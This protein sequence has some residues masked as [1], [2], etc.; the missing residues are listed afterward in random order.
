[1]AELVSF[2]SVTHKINGA[3]ADAIRTVTAADHSNDGVETFVVL[4]T[5][6]GSA[7]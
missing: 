7:T 2:G 6:E 5:G 4:N 1:L 3:L